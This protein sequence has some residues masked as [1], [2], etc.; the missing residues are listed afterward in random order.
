VTAA[1]SVA[2]SI[3]LLVPA[4]TAASAGQSDQLSG[5]ASCAA[6]GTVALHTSVDAAGTEHGTAVV[7]GVSVRKW[8]GSLSL[9]A[10]Y[11]SGSG[12]VAT[13]TAKSGRFVVSATAAG[14][15]T[16]DALAAFFATSLKDGCVATLSQQKRAV[17]VTDGSSGLVVREGAK[18]LVGVLVVGTKRH[19]Y[20]IDFTIKD[21]KKVERQR[22]VRTANSKGKLHAK[23]H[24]PRHLSPAAVVSVRATDLTKR[25][26]PLVFTLG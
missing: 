16:H 1:L 13:Y 5:S 15:Q 14:A 25:N 24:A 7:K 2:A 19:R 22:L 12:D 3:A 11:G 26:Q 23:A 10:D 9:G 6:G 20:Q 4:S 21:G 18:P 17:V 8:A